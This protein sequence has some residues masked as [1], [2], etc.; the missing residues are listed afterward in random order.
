MAEWTVQA[1]PGHK[2]GIAQV[3]PQNPNKYMCPMS[4]VQGEGCQ[5]VGQG[6]GGAGV[7]ICSTKEVGVAESSHSEKR[8]EQI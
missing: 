7:G 1:K 5:G 6:L 3:C 8:Q 4:L 2:G